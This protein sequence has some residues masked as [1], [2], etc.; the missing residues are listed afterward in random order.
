LER[1]EE[2][3]T[4]RPAYQTLIN[5]RIF[6][7][8]ILYR[9]LILKHHIPSIICRLEK[10]YKWKSTYGKPYPLDATKILSKK[11]GMMYHYYLKV[12]PTQYLHSSQNGELEVSHQFSVTRMEKDILAGASGIPGAF[13]QYEFS[14]LM[15][16]YEERL[17]SLSDFFVSLCAIIGGV[18]TVASLVDYLIYSSSKAIQKK[19]ITEKFG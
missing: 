12:V 4:L 8:F 9:Q 1:L 5:L 16:H 11:S 3:F 15:V 19:M 13:F 18:Y 2:I 17:R 7:T 14:P 6:M 10:K